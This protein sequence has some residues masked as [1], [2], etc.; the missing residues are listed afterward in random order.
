[1]IIPAHTVIAFGV[2]ELWVQRNGIFV[3]TELEKLSE[4][5]QLL[6]VLPIETRSSLL[7]LLRNMMKN[8]EEVSA[9]E[10]VLDQ[11]C[12]GDSPN[13]GNL[14][15]SERRTVQ[16][17]VDIILDIVGDDKEFRSSLLSAI[18][19][20]VSVMDEMTDEGLSVLESCCRPP[21]LKALQMLTQPSLQSLIEVSNSESR[22]LHLIGGRAQ[23]LSDKRFSLLSTP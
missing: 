13:L 22:L 1:M 7:Q 10:S 17:I 12:D 9:M 21:V 16:A 5:F 6:S 3:L 19:L 2:I 4:Q 14:R 11:M 8:R 15:E 20:I 23:Y 18:H